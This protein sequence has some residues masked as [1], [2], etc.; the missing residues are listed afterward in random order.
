MSNR[1]HMHPNLR[2]IAPDAPQRR[3][4]KHHMILT[5]QE[6]PGT[7]EIRCLCGEVTWT[8][9]GQAHAEEIAKIHL[10]AAGQ[11][12]KFRRAVVTH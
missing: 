1:P 7:F 10:W 8:P 9:W 6:C 2:P 3:G 11:G 12:V 4:V 5:E